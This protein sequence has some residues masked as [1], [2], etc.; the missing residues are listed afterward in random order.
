MDYLDFFSE[1][2]KV[3][4]FQKEVNKTKFGGFLFII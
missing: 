1:S 3:Y 4:I 2:P